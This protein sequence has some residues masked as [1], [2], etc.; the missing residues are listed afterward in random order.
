MSKRLAA[1]L[2][3]L[4][5]VPLAP[6]AP[7]AASAAP[8]APDLTSYVNPFV[9]SQDGGP[10]FGHGGG[11]GMNFPGA[12]TPFGMMQWSPDTVRTSGGGYKYEDNR[13]RGFSMTHISGPGCTG[14]QDFPVVPLSGTIGRSPATHGAD[15]V[16]TFKH[17]NE[18]A[19]PG[20]YGVTTDTG[21]K[22]ELTATNR[23]GVGRFTFPA[24]KPGTV[25]V[26]VTGSI[27]GVEDAEATIKGNTVYGW[28]K[29]GGFCGTKNQYYVY[30]HATFDRPVKAYGT[31]K[32]DSVQPGDADAR[33]SAP[34]K[35]PQIAPKTVG[36]IHNGPAG[37]PLTPERRAFTGDVNVKGPG[38][39]LY[40][41]FDSDQPVQMK[42]G[43]SYVS[44]DGAKANLKREVGGHD[45]DKVRDDARK[46]W[47]KRLGQVKITGGA[48]DRLKTFYTA[49]YH[50]FLQPY[51]FDD[52]DGTYT[53]F[54]YRT[55]K[56]RKG[57]HQYATFSGWDIYRS[58]AQLLSFLAP[59]VASDIAQSMYD[60]AHSIGDVWDRWSHQNTVTGVMNGDPYHS[61]IAS[62]Y[63]FGARDFDAK[64]ALT[65]MTAGAERVGP[66]SG[67]TER[68]GNAQYL[69]LG[70]VPG[71]VATTEEYG[72]ADF[73]IA[74]LAGRLGDDATAEKYMQRSH[75]WQN[76][77]NPLNGWIQPRFADGSFFSPFDPADSGWYV[78]GNGAQYHWM[79]YPDVKSLFNAM[80]G[81]EEAAKRL[82]AFFAKLNAGPHEPLAY[83]GNEPSLQSPWLY[84]WAGKPY[85]TQDVVRRARTELFKPTPNGLVGNDDLGTMSAWYVWASMGMYP[86]IPGRAELMVNGP[87]FPK[88]E[89]RRSSGQQFTI[90]APGAS[91]ST[92]YVQSLKVDGKATSKAWLPE[93][94]ASKGGKL[95]FTMGSAPNTEF[96]S[97]EADAPPSFGEGGR[98]YLTAVS[99]G[100][101]PLEPGGSGTTTLRVQS[102]TGG[103]DVTWKANP[104]A[105]ITVTPS[106]GTLKVPASGHADQQVTISVAADAKVD[107]HSVP[108]EIPGAGDAGVTVNVAHKGTIEWYQN[109]AGISDDDNPGL[110]NFD[111]GGWS[112]SSQALAAAGF[113]PG[114]QVT[115]NGFTFGWPGRKP[116]QLDNVQAMGQTVELTDAPKAGKLAF[117]GSAGNGDVQ[118]T[119]TVTYTD[120]STQN[121]TVGLSDWALSADAYP[122]RFGNEIVAKTPYRNSGDGTPD[123]IN[124]YVFGAAPIGLDASKQVKSFKL[125]TPS[126]GGGSFHVFA[127]AFGG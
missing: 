3:A 61:I 72:A 55:H 102:L 101:I 37:K 77:Y 12:V 53:G 18:Q 81:R 80:G 11:A 38:T 83:L 106:S 127:W 120:G 16:Q 23:A 25:L 10:D 30:F 52:A 123:K 6:F 19:S 62:A 64:G 29:T 24:G 121:A 82:D 71:D 115:W 42:S 93:S 58:E 108:F 26:N 46:D 65:S 87:E 35:V 74:Q 69:K 43:L 57:H 5:L 88:I 85:R 124:V 119:V 111:G 8:A 68:P 13:L 109:N 112:Y 94:F 47:Q 89:I 104:P 17:E 99:P 126:T 116:G 15:Y 54:D 110:A 33:G 79:T 98:S 36:R 44:V 32:D 48:A 27:N 70:Y 66:K 92:P 9:G 4:L 21:V 56:V 91:D 45:F 7:T 95:D 113:G 20:Y 107:Y 73:G 39:G 28:A 49:L 78:E 86:V 14:A 114:K 22:T 75:G 125:N 2:F 90:T 1:G 122:P 105:G 34:A 63:A 50:A 40:L 67:Y 41:Q 117:L 97:A 76:L 84:A 51:V 100:L 31:W 60:D 118:T 103:G 59:D 96:G